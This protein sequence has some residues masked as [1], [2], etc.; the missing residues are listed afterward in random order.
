MNGDEKDISNF[1][2]NCGP[3]MGAFNSF[4]KGTRLENW[5]DRHADEIAVLIM[6]KAAEKMN[7]FFRERFIAG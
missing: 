4:V 3:A 1:Q 5:R 2:I 7:E 6:E